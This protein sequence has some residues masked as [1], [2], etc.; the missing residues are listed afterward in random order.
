VRARVRARVGFPGRVNIRMT[1]L[2]KKQKLLI[3]EMINKGFSDK[4]ISR[5]ADVKIDV[6]KDF[7]GGNKNVQNRDVKTSRRSAKSIEHGG[8]DQSH[9]DTRSKD[10]G[11]KPGSKDIND[12]PTGETKPKGSAGDPGSKGS[13]DFVGGKKSMKKTENPKEEEEDE[14]QCYNCDHVQ[15]TPFTECPKCG[16][17]NTFE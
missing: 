1:G 6:I 9:V 7:R 2:S 17:R 15:G 12:T 5:M 4:D 8:G 11:R 10:Q 3:Y 13:I 16:A 14:Y